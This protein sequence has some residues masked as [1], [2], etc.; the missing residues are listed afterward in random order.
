MPVMIAEY[1]C[2][3]SRAIH[4]LRMV[5]EQ[6]TAIAFAVKPGSMAISESQ[7][8]VSTPS[9]RATMT[10]LVKETADTINFVVLHEDMTN[11]DFRW[12]QQVLDTHPES[13]L[14]PMWQ[15]SQ[16]PS[17]QSA[18]Y[19]A[20][21]A[22]PFGSRIVPPDSLNVGF[23]LMD[24][25][26]IHSPATDISLPTV[27][28]AELTMSLN[29]RAREFRRGGVFV[30]AFIARTEET[31]D[32]SIIERQY[33]R[34]NCFQEETDL[35]NSSRP[36]LFPAAVSEQDIP[37][38]PS[39]TSPLSE[40]PHRDIWTAMS[41]MIVPCLQRLVSCGMMKI[42]VAR[43]MLTLPMYPRT[44]SQTLRVLEKFSDIWTLEWSCGLGRSDTHEIVSEL[45]EKVS[46]ESEPDT[47]R[48][49]QPA[50]MA[51][52]TG[53]ILPSAYNEHVIN[54]FKNLYETHFRVVL[55]ERGKLNKGA[56]EFIL[57]SLWDVLR[58]RMGDP[59]TCPLAD[60]ELEVQLI[61]L[62]RL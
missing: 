21:V 58:S 43:S 48:L 39:N 56:V 12:F 49:P 23:S 52:K 4:L 41:D 50:W 8:S 16:T 9:H 20:F 15:S 35:T 40:K 14:D 30:L 5:L 10:G 51:L 42:D 2:M 26:W 38:K 6:L 60:C 54:M 46:L 17:L 24:L 25:H 47:L 29:A 37:I 34:M 44:A 7:N 62:R 45:G 31:N 53:K 36:K 1:G 59:Q 18:I 19:N 61:A 28:H 32:E 57:D 55:R 22:R 33:S 27:A 13:Y 11:S 3:N